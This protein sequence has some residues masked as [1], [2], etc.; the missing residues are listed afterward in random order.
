V[1]AVKKKIKPH[2]PSGFKG[3]EQR[4]QKKIFQTRDK[5]WE[6]RKGWG[7]EKSR[8]GGST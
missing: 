4:G 6:R 2:K 7:N 5:V 1:R 3:Q 8:P